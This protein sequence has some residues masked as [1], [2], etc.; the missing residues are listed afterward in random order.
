[1]PVKKLSLILNLIKKNKITFLVLVL[2]IIG[3][4]IFTK[5]RA[6]PQ[7]SQTVEVKRQDIKSFVSASGTLTGANVVNLHFQ[8]GGKLFTL[9][10]KAGDVVK[11]GQVIA[12]LDATKELSAVT[13]AQ[14][15][16]RD[17]EA[18]LRKVYDDIHLFQY[19]NGGFG[20]VGSPNE[21]ETQR[22][23]RTAAEVIKDNAFDEIKEAQKALADTALFSPV[24]GIILKAD[25]VAGQN[26][27]AA[28]TIVQV[29]DTQRIIFEAEVDEADSAKVAKQ[30]KA[31]VTL[32]AYSDLVLEGAVSEIVPVTKTTSSGAAVVIVRITLD[33]P[34]IS[35]TQGLNGQSA[36]I[37]KEEKEALI[38]PL[39]ALREDN[40][41]VLQQ[42]GFQSRQVTL[43][44]KSDTDVEIKTGLKEGDK[45]ILTPP[46]NTRQSRGL[47]ERIQRLFGGGRGR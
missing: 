41:V 28:D 27:T 12:N 38:I 46:Q 2:A 8:S 5:V 40:T 45:I 18:A 26:V 21:T 20:N 37:Q 44:I 16:L 24:T 19:G 34:N 43:G 4:I 9:N 23:Q 33:S 11:K 39:E 29:A 36:I 17:K 14:N 25:F 7:P 32:D 6:R 35:F 13:Q 15:T 47:F 3:L 1:M 42:D 22:A 30:Q 10:V 31:E